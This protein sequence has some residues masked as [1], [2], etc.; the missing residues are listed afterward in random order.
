MPS[1]AFF[2]P[3]L[4]VL[5]PRAL[6]HAHPVC[7]LPSP[8]VSRVIPGVCFLAYASHLFIFPPVSPA[9]LPAL[10]EA[11][12]LSINFGYLVPLSFPHATVALHPIFEALFHVVV[13][14]AVL[15]LAFLSEDIPTC[16]T[17]QAK[18]FLLMTPFLTNLFLLPYLTLR[19]PPMAPLTTLPQTDRSPLISFAESR[20]LPL[21]AVGLVGVSAVWAAIGRQEFGG[22]MERW[23]SFLPLINGD[24]LCH[25]FVVDLVV[26]ALFQAWLV[27][28]DA[29]RRRW[30]QNVNV[31]KWIWIARLIPLFG[32]AAYL[33]KRATNAPIDWQRE[34]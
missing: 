23:M 3:V 14:W 5:P 20:M 21:V 1:L 15:F 4:P 13:A 18:P 27:Q 34:E 31:E 6:V 32:L 7:R 30:A 19:T 25:S 22:W 2:S 10:N 8:S 24:I 33:Y 9:P 26:F 17:I 12:Q 28:D 29:K 16:S 11:F